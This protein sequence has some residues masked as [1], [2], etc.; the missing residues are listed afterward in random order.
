MSPISAAWIRFAVIACLSRADKVAGV[1]VGSVV[2]VGVS[3]IEV[4]GAVGMVEA[5]A[6]GGTGVVPAQPVSQNNEKAN[7]R[8]NLDDSFSFLFST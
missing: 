2:K 5:V 3:E 6:C 7:K 8:I 4:A 1:T